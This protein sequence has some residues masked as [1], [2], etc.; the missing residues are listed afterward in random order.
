MKLILNCLRALAITCLSHKGQNSVQRTTCKVFTQL[1]RKQVC[2]LSEQASI[3]TGK[4]CYNSK[5]N[6]ASSVHSKQFLYNKNKTS[7]NLILITCFMKLAMVCSNTTL[8]NDERRKLNECLTE[9]K[10]L[11]MNLLS[12]AKT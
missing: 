8:S 12:T 2:W 7:S 11:G 4:A 6:T 3:R 5:Q 1:S 9:L 10:H